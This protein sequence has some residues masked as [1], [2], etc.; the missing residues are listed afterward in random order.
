[1]ACSSSKRNA[2][3]RPGQLRLADA[4]S[5]PGRGTSRSAGADP[6]AR[7]GP[8]GRRR[9][10]PRSPRPGRRPA[11]GARSSMWTSL[12]ISPSMSRLTGIPVQAATISAMSSA[13]TSSFSSAPGP[14]ERRER[15]LLV[16]HA[17]LELDQRAVLELGGGPVVGLALGLLDPRWSASSSALVVRSAAD[18]RLL[19]LP[20]LLHRPGLLGDLAELGLEGLRGGPSRRRPSPCGAPRARSPAGSA[21]APARRARPAW[22]R[23]PCAAGWPPRRRGR[24]P[25]RAGSGR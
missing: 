16:L 22:S 24:S 3:E 1:M 18:R 21:A 23:S 12:A 20:A 25:C 13:S 5:G 7:R 19:G 11:R 4:R 10:P 14:S 2:G 8:G 17:L 9:R 15:G 6:Q